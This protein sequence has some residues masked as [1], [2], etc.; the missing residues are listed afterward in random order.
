M[1]DA[2]QARQQAEDAANEALAT[3]AGRFVGGTTH[4]V[5]SATV[6]VVRDGTDGIEVFF[7]ER[8]LDSDFAG[9]AYAFPG[10]KVDRLDAELDDGRWTGIDPARHR[11]ALGAR[12]D[13]HVI[14]LYVAAVRETFEEAGLLLARRADGAPI[15]GDDL[16]SPSFEQARTR[17]ATR[18]QHWD[19]RG[20][21]EEEDVVLDLGA[22]AP[23]SWWTTPHGMHRRFD[24]RFFVAA[25]PPEQ[26]DALIHDDVETTDSVWMTP[27]AA[28]AAHEAGTAVVIYPTR[29][30]LEALATHASVADVLEAGRRGRTD[31]RR[32]LP[33]IALV[34]G[35]PMVHHPDGGP[36]A[37][38]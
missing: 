27:A 31:M 25:A 4:P 20:W 28:V 34:D 19:W 33:L 5:D 8:H 11:V 29:C 9:G 12:S 38:V 7:L 32:I 14:A 23:F 18:G 26:V 2:E 15:G 6:M 35:V 30:N 22:L 24:T 17:L 3:A 13:R 36:P 37:T 10:G 16:A 21:L 1:A